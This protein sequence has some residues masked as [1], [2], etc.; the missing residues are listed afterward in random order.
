VTNRRVCLTFV[1][2]GV[3]RSDGVCCI[4]W[5]LSW[6]VSLHLSLTPWAVC[7]L[8]QYAEYVEGLHA[9]GIEEQP[10]CDSC[11]ANRLML[12][13][14][15]QTVANEFYDP[16][17]T[18][19]QARWAESLLHTLQVSSLGSAWYCHLANPAAVM[20]WQ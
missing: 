14:A 4:S 17:G 13:K 1:K 7:R 18:F 19:N 15:W 2:Q 12:E 5:N 3:S 11:T 9:T 20:K 8:Q 6:Q 10:G 16:R